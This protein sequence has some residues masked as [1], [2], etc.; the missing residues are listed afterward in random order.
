MTYVWFP[1]NRI[2]IDY[3]FLSHDKPKYIYKTKHNWHL[4]TSKQDA[5]EFIIFRLYFKIIK[6]DDDFEIKS[7]YISQTHSR[8]LVLTRVLSSKMAI[9]GLCFV[10]YFLK[11]SAGTQV[12]I[13]GMAG[14]CGE[15]RGV[16][17]HPL[18]SFCTSAENFCTSPEKSCTSPWESFNDRSK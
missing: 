15:V 12:L 11:L 18:I 5:N 9:F 17:H 1:D 3:D 2:L 7:K 16:A 10:L 6:S 4:E 14:F 13:F 8:R